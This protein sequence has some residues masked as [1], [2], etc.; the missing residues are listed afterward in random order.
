MLYI[1]VPEVASRNSNTSGGIYS[2]DDV[3]V[4]SVHLTHTSHCRLT[5]H[6]CDS[7]YEVCSFILF[8]I[9]NTHP[10]FSIMATGHQKAAVR[11]TNTAQ[12]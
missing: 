12:L 7:E 5:T 1:S 8:G 3:I 2:T 10:K 9:S 4:S 11:T 6:L